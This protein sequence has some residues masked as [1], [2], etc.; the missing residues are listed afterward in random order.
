M[1]SPRQHLDQC[2]DELQELVNQQLTPGLSGKLQSNL[3]GC[4]HPHRAAEG[5]TA[6]VMPCEIKIMDLV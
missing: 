4:C 2:W 6:S 3:M 1:V 5:S